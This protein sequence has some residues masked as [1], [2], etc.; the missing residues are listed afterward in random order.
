MIDQR[1]SHSEGKRTRGEKVTP[2]L[3]HQRKTRERK[4]KNT[5]L[6][7]K[8]YRKK[9]AARTTCSSS[10]FI[11][12]DVSCASSLSAPPFF[13]CGSPSVSQGFRCAA[14]HAQFVARRKRREPCREDGGHGALSLG[15]YVLI[16]HTNMTRL[17]P[18]G[19]GLML[20][21]YKFTL[22][23]PASQPRALPSGGRTARRGR[24]P[25]L[26]SPFVRL[27]SPRSPGPC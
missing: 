24:R 12:L 2:P 20:G 10:P 4:K 25:G 21:V 19:H 8:S 27:P 9:S 6:K 18:G 17:A 15:C 5:I 7:K 3:L 26:P 11:R 14:L 16:Y 1:P 13:L 23:P 22:R